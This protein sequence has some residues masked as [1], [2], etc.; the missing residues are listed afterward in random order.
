MSPSRLPTHEAPAASADVAVR[1]DSRGPAFFVQPRFGRDGRVFRLL[2]FRSMHQHADAALA[3][4][5]AACPDRSAEW[6]RHHKLRD[7]P[8]ITRVGRLRKIR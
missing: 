5:L 6:D 3:E 7:D 4:H 8:R 1:L 2:K